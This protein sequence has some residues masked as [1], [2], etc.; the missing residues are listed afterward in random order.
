MARP[1]A[2]TTAPAMAPPVVDCAASQRAH[3]SSK[4][5][6]TAKRSFKTNSKANKTIKNRGLKPHA[7]KASHWVDRQLR[8]SDPEEGREKISTHCPASVA[9][10]FPRF[11]L[12]SVSQN[13]GAASTFVAEGHPHPVQF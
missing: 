8:P 7:I 1:W 12:P 13:D 6:T 5:H 3:K 11:F 9:E 4:R 2:S 10:I